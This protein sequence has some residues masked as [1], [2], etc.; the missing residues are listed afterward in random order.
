LLPQIDAQLAVRHAETIE[1]TKT[2]K[3]STFFGGVT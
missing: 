2:T 3:A 1:R